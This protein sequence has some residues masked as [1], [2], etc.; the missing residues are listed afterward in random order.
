[1]WK[2]K[3]YNHLIFKM[4]SGI[5]VVKNQLLETAYDDDVPANNFKPQLINIIVISCSG[6]FINESPN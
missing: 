4:Y 5:Y 1:M 3:V 2:A 6:N